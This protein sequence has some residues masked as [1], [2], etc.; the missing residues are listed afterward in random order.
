MEKLRP[1][2]RNTGLT[3]GGHENPIYDLLGSIRKITA[4][5]MERLEGVLSDLEEQKTIFELAR[6]MFG[7]LDGYDELLAIEEAGAHVEYL[8]D[9]ARVR[10]ANWQTLAE[11]SHV[12]WQF[13]CAD[14]SAALALCEPGAHR[15]AQRE[16]Q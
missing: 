15:K 13:V 1:L 12:P 5:H 4:L 11:K 8:A 9:R 7:E 16:V 3:L 2:G 10:L 6:G 14:G